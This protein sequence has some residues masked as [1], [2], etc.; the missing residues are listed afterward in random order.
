MNIPKIGTN[1]YRVWL[2]RNVAQ[3]KE[4]EMAEMEIGS[5]KHQQA[6]SKILRREENRRTIN[7]INKQAQPHQHKYV[8]LDMYIAECECGHVKER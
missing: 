2:R 8:L 7:S 5:L 1:L 3:Y 4:R 6:I